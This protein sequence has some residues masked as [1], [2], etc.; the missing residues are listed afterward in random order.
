MMSNERFEIPTAESLGGRYRA[1]WLAATPFAL[2]ITFFQLSL[3][4]YWFGAADR[5]RIFLYYHD[6]GPQVPDTSPFSAV[7][8]SLGALRP[9]AFADDTAHYDDF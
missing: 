9:R 2:A 6:M 8:A 3:F 1:P 4:A 5:Y 7:T